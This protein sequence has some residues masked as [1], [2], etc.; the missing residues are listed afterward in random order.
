MQGIPV[1]KKFVE[2]IVTGAILGPL[3]IPLAVTDFSKLSGA[4][5]GMGMQTAFLQPYS[6]Y[7][8]PDTNIG[9]GVGMIISGLIGEVSAIYEIS[10]QPLMCN[11]MKDYY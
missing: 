6:S 3:I 11:I 7:F 4:F 1:D 8:S 5:I 9:I 10:T 2:G